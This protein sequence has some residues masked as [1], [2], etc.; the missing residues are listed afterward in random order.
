M[1]ISEEVIAKVA[2]FGVLPVLFLL[3]VIFK[4]PVLCWVFLAGAAATV[5]AM[6]LREMVDSNLRL[7]S[8]MI[9]GV[10]AVVALIQALVAQLYMM[11]KRNISWRSY[12]RSLIEENKWRAARYGTDAKLI[13]LGIGEERPF[14]ELAHELVEFVSDA[15]EALGTVDYLQGVLRIAKEGTSAHRQ[16]EVYEKSGGDLNA[17]VDFLIEETMRGI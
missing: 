17:V 9:C 4:Q 5:A 7:V 16:L 1:P 12:P 13:D 6:W 2:L 10:L 11:H 15:A 8:T 14:A 3:A